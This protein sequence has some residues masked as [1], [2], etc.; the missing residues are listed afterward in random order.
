[1]KDK[2]EIIVI[3]EGNKGFFGIFGKKLVVVKLVEKIDLI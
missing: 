2:V 3:E 1:M